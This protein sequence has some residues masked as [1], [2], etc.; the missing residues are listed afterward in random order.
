MHQFRTKK[1]LKRPRET[2]CAWTFFSIS[3]FRVNHDNFSSS[4][5]NRE[6]SMKLCQNTYF[7]VYIPN[8]QSILVE[9]WPTTLVFTW[10]Q[11][12]RSCDIKRR[13]KTFQF[14]WEMK[15]NTRRTWRCYFFVD[16]R[17][18]VFCF[19]LFCWIRR[20]FCSSR[21]HQWLWSGRKKKK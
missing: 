5:K 12:L 20:E 16:T 11:N 2:L 15:H 3:C 10:L 17:L 4:V 18:P 8:L 1:T 13:K 9:S 7:N 19:V 6:K 21:K 14:I